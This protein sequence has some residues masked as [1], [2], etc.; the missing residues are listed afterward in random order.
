MDQVKMNKLRFHN[1]T[2][3]AGLHVMKDTAKHYKLELTGEIEKCVHCAVEKIRKKNI[4]KVNENKSSIPGERM[5]LDI[6]SMKHDSQGGKKHW[7]MLVDEATGYKKSFFMKKK[8]D[9]VVEIAQWLKNLN[10]KRGIKVKM[11]RCDNAGEN[12]SLEEWCDK[13]GLGITFEYTAPGTPQQNGVVERAFVTVMGRGRTMMNYAGLTTRKRRMLW[14]EVASTA[15]QI[16]NILVYGDRQIPAFE[17]FYGEEAKYAKHLR[18]FGEMCVTVDGSNKTGR[19]KIDPRGRVCMFLGYS[20]KHAG[21]CY[22]F[23]NMHQIRP[24]TAGN[25]RV[26]LMSCTASLYAPLATR[27]I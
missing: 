15:T 23:L 4:A 2:G 25:G 14:C 17:A 13:E 22:R 24:M 19:T 27:S 9:Q 1:L 26:S 20:T 8:S 21:D 6:S 7:A 5:Y 10:D 16:D 18:I 11:I 3:H 12:K